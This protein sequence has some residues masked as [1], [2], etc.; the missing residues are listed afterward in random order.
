[1]A[2]A[3]YLARGDLIHIAPYPALAGLNRPHQRMTR[4]VKMLGRVLVLRGIAAAHASTLQAHPQVHP[5][6]A[7]LDAFLANVLGRLRKFDLIQVS[8]LI[9]HS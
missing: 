3:R 8:T 7:H 5:R 4:R 9:R 1:L 2:L 6:I